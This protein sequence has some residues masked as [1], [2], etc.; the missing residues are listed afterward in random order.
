MPTPEETMRA[1]FAE[2]VASTSKLEAFV[3]SVREDL[4]ALLASIERSR[5]NLASLARDG[6][7][8]RVG[9]PPAAV[10]AELARE[11]KLARQLR[12]MAGEAA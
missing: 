1:C 9:V 7:Y 12:K 6:T 10:A 3:A 5:A 2:S 11:W 4:A 8:A